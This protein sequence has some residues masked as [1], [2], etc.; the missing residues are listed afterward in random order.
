[1]IGIMWAGISSRFWA[2]LAAVGAALLVVW[3]IVAGIQRAERDRIA[4]AQAEQARKQRNTR[5]EIDRSVA[6]EPDAI[7]RLRD[8]W[9]RPN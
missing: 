5:D 2:V 7:G 6:R 3:R 4:A 1:M 9:Q 8:K